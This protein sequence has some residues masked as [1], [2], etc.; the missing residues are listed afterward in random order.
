[1]GKSFSYFRIYIDAATLKLHKPPTV[2]QWLLSNFRIYIDAAT[3][4]P[5]HQ[6]ELIAIPRHFRIY[7]DAATLKRAI[8][9]AGSVI[10]EISASI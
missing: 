7:I 8:T 2:A 4:K 6:S 5:K 1:M 3:L 10:G 9:S